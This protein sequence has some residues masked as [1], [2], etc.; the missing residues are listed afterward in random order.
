MAGT[1]RRRPSPPTP[2]GPPTCSRP[3]SSTAPSADP[4]IVLIAEGP[5]GRAQKL[6][7]AERRKVERVA[8]G[9]P[10]TLLRVGDG[11]TEDEVTIRKLANRVQRM[12]PVLTKDE[13][14]VVNKRL[15]SIGGV[16]PP[17]PKGV[18]PTK[19]RMDRKAMRGR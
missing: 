7:A 16:R 4:G 9:V 17:L 15:K 5:S 2:S 1:S 8:S 18:D 13:V 14:S 6:L 10:V 19:V 3:P 11:G 12:K